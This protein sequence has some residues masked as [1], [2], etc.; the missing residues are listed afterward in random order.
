MKRSSAALGLAAVAVV[1]LAGCAAVA[2]PGRSSG[3]AWRVVYNGYGS[4]LVGT[5]HAADIIALRPASPSGAQSSHA[6]LVL[7]RRGWRD[8]SIEVR[9]RTTRQ[10]RRPQPNP[11][12][13]GWLLWHYQDDTHF[14]YLAL[15]PNGW[16]LGKEDPAYPG[17]QRYLATGSSPDFA[18]GRWYVVRV[19]QHGPAI[20]VTVD[21]KSLV[22]V[23]DTQD[24]Y[25]SGRVGLYAE[26]ASATFQLVSASSR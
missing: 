24:P 9:M 7:S 14:Y 12:E 19:R 1:G 6:A 15:K 18:L 21:G 23:T 16:E 22:R 26:D 5:G 2:T 17:N 3:R 4:V 8:M 11:W 25:M 13:V 10:L 20:D